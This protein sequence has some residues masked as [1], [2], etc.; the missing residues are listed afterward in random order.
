MA[1]AKHVAKHKSLGAKFSVDSGDSGGSG[2][3]ASMV[4]ENAAYEVNL[5]NAQTQD[6]ESSMPLR[7][8]L[9]LPVSTPT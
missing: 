5:T 4:A 3:S 1:S 6:T 2:Q 8:H 7:F 9:Y